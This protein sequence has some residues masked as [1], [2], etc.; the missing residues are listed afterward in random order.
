MNESIR[1]ISLES[2]ANRPAIWHQSHVDMFAF[3]RC[4]SVTLNFAFEIANMVVTVIAVHVVNPEHGR[5]S[6]GNIY[7]LL[8]CTTDPTISTVC[9]KWLLNIFAPLRLP[10]VRLRSRPTLASN[11]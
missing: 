2:R 9:T 5:L 4:L 3:A 8:A 11:T 10:R 6:A 1:F 7:T